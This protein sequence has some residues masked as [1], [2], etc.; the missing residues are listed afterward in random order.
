MRKLW[1][2]IVLLPLLCLCFAG[3][4][5]LDESDEDIITGDYREVTSL[6]SDEKVVLS[7]YLSPGLADDFSSALSARLSSRTS[8][9]DNALAAAVTQAEFETEPIKEFYASGRPVVVCRPDRSFLAGKGIDASEDRLFA[10]VNNY[11][12]FCSSPEPSGGM[13]VGDCLNGLVSWLNDL[14]LNDAYNADG[15]SLLREYNFKHNFSN[16]VDNEITHIIFSSSDHLKG[17]WNVQ[18]TL[19]VSPL[20]GFAGSFGSATDYYFVTSS[21]SVESGKMYSGNFTKKHGGVYARICGYY[22]R[23]L[24]SDFT[25][26]N[27]SGK[28]VGMFVQVPSPATV[29]N[30]S[31][32]T[33][34]WEASIGGS[35]TGGLDSSGKILGATVSAGYTHTSSTSRTTS[36]CDIINV[37]KGSKASYDYIFNNLPSYN[38]SAI[39]I[40]DPPLITV[41]TADFY[42]QWIWAVPTQD[43]D[44]TTKYKVRAD[45]SNFVY[46]ASY[47]YT[48]AADYHNLT[49]DMGKYSATFELPVPGRYPT[50]KFIL[51]NSGE[52]T[53]LS[54]V[55]L[56]NL[57]YSGLEEF[58]DASYWAAGQSSSMYLPVGKY[59]LTCDI[60]GIDKQ[61]RHYSY[62]GEFEIQE[63]GETHLDTGYGFNQ[64]N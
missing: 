28:E 62:S 55:R 12:E 39:A 30:A 21:I 19:K 20:H 56:K 46:G 17:S 63:G 5:G 13:N 15:E 34:G 40:R 22:L 31:S 8:A 32:Y 49:F 27:S 54:N 45:L 24:H 51:K 44:R 57:T 64:I 26:L 41:S 53:I 16:A 6:A 10:G 38:T 23:S 4:Q 3:C 58:S 52:G 29:I 50:G 48:T 1:N 9:L 14:M 33:T 2:D 47:F 7:V 35:L 61:N 60:K 37:H 43:K 36:D 42:S 11:G 25:L 18:V 59:K